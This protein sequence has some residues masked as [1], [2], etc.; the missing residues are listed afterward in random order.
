M[1][2]NT[3]VSAR[4][5]ELRPAQLRTLE[6]VKT[7]IEKRLLAEETA[8]MAQKEGEAKLAS[9]NK[10]E[11]IALAWGQPQTVVRQPMRGLAAEAQRVIFKAPA[12]KLPAY[13][14]MQLPNGTYMLYR[15]SQVKTGTAKGETDPRPKALR[16]Q[17]AQL[18]GAEDFNAFLAALRQRYKVKI[19]KSALAKGANE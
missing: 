11:A 8:R 2:P 19:D 15:I 4:I 17:L 9:L 1:A 6:S 3:L 7:E 16:A 5:L 18:Y 10:G 13:A 14:G 12:G